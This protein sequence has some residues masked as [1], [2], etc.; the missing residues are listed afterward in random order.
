MERD[1]CV[2]HIMGRQRL[3]VLRTGQLQ[4]RTIH[5]TVDSGDTAETARE[6]INSRI[7]LPA[8]GEKRDRWT[9]DTGTHVARLGALARALAAV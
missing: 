1:S 5:G 8:D 9:L 3:L 6:T 4:W 7:S 2:S